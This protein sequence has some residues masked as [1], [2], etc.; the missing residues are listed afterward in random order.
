MCKTKI[1]A[2]TRAGLIAAVYAALTLIWPFSFGPVQVR[3]SEALTVLPLFCGY[4]VYGLFLGCLLSGI[5]SGSVWFDI[6]FGAFATLLS[7]LLTRKFAKKA[8]L[9][10]MFPV[11]LNAL[12]VGPVVHF[13][14]AG[15][16]SLGALP[17]TVLT[18]GLGEAVACYGL[19]L[20]LA[21]LLRRVSPELW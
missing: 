18:V 1:S 8:P 21:R 20:P 16:P 2:L 12:I 14:Y 7:A 5:L 11:L 13:A 6:V 19:G 17:Y 4:S 15:N 9:V 3:V 10:L